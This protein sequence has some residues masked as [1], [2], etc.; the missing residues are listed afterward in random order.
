MS[1]CELNYVLPV[2]CGWSSRVET[3]GTAAFPP[4]CCCRLCD[5][6]LM[7]ENNPQ[8]L[9]SVRCESVTGLARSFPPAPWAS[10]WQLSW[11]QPRLW[12]DAVVTQRRLTTTVPRDV[13]TTP[14]AIVPLASAW[15]PRARL[16]L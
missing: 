11:G 2:L 6:Y 14:S 16:A 1:Y 9:L 10:L 7:P 8:S 12:K 5:D 3:T 15:L 13:D 4:P